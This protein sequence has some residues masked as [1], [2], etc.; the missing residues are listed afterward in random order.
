MV[1]ASFRGAKIAPRKVCR[2]RPPHFLDEFQSSKRWRPQCVRRR[3]PAV[4]LLP[5]ALMRCDAINVGQCLCRL[6]PMSIVASWHVMKARISGSDLAGPVTVEHASIR[7]RSRS[8][9]RS[10][11]RS[12]RR[13]AILGG[14]ARERDWGAAGKEK[15][16]AGSTR[17]AGARKSLPRSL[18]RAGRVGGREIPQAASGRGE[19]WSKQGW[20]GSIRSGVAHGGRRCAGR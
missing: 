19:W 17:A 10:R 6:V 15:G 14:S 3:S 11:S 4:R 2:C 20:S 13:A 12:A 7:G 18:G 16:R 9:S 1:F 5:C 8:S